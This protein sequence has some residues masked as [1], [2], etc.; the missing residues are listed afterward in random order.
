M[1]VTSSINGCTLCGGRPA[2]TFWSGEGPL[3]DGCVDERVSARMGVPRLP[4]APEPVTVVAADGRPRV[5]R[6]RLWRAPTGISVR[7]VQDGADPEAGFEFA[8]FGD[9][10]ADVAELIDVVTGRA[11]ARTLWR[12]R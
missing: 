11:E 9:H 12:W 3:C 4:K 10:D 8:E 2:N 5:M 1:G 7:L 6:Y